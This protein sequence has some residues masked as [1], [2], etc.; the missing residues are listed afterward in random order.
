MASQVGVLVACAADAAAH[1]V[2]SLIITDTEQRPLSLKVAISW[3]AVTSLECSRPSPGTFYD[4]LESWSL[5]EN[6]LP[7]AVTAQPSFCAIQVVQMPQSP[8]HQG[9]L[10]PVCTVCCHHL[11]WLARQCHLCRLLGI[12][13]EDFG[14]N[15]FSSFRHV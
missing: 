15:F 9:C 1:H 7:Q 8:Y 13:E 4:F 14:P 2:H 11:Y 5:A 6:Y 12:L 10:L 3:F